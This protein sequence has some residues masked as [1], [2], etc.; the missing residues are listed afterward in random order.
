M[1]LQRADTDTWC[2]HS[3]RELNWRRVAAACGDLI[4]FFLFLVFVPMNFILVFKPDRWRQVV[5]IV[6]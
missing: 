4:L 5:Q 1:L 6:V 2:D 3:A